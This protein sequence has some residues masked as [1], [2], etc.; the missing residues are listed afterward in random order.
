[1]AV[2]TWFGQRSV[3]V[4]CVFGVHPHVFYFSDASRPR[5]SSQNLKIFLL[6]FATNGSQTTQRKPP[7]I[8]TDDLKR[9]GADAL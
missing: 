4:K 7:M 5:R 6:V 3:L 2:G 1:M 8:E 9:S